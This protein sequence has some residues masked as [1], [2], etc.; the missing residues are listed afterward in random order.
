MQKE[1]KQNNN[2]ITISYLSITV[3]ASTLL[4]IYFFLFHATNSF[5]SSIS[6]LAYCSLVSC[7]PLPSYYL[8][9]RSLLLLIPI[10]SSTNPVDGST[11]Q[12]T[13]TPRSHA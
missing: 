5:S 6:F 1:W 12:K 10:T 3:L 4:S 7:S 8:I 13:P 11:N 9:N 2:Y